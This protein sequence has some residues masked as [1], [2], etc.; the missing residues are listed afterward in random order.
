MSPQYI[1]YGFEG[2]QGRIYQKKRDSYEPDYTRPEALF[3][4]SSKVHKHLPEVVKLIDFHLCLPR[5]T[6]Y[7][8]V[9]QDQLKRNGFYEEWKAWIHARGDLL[10]DPETQTSRAF[11]EFW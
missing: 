1:G 8:L 6:Y 7:E 9:I 3:M 2:I 4:S 11:Q 10:C 5:T